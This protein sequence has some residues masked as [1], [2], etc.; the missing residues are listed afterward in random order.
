MAL[1]ASL[2]QG[3]T[4]VLRNGS[5]CVSVTFLSIYLQCYFV[6]LQRYIFLFKV[7]CTHHVARFVVCSLYSL[8]YTL[9]NR[10]NSS[11]IFVFFYLYRFKIEALHFYLESIDKNFRDSFLFSTILFGDIVISNFINEFIYALKKATM[12]GD[13]HSPV[14]AL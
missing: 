13:N 6:L 9:V 5:S 7:I 12:N 2:Y 14:F 10:V 3:I 4:V 11:C 8:I 1:P